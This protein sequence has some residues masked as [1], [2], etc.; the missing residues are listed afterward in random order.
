MAG[1]CGT[2]NK[3]HRVSEADDDSIV[4]FSYGMS[5][6]YG[7]AESEKKGIDLNAVECLRANKIESDQD[8]LPLECPFN[9]SLADLTGVSSSL[10][11]KGKEA[12]NSPFLNLSHS[13]ASFEIGMSSLLINGGNKAKPLFGGDRF[14]PC[15]PEDTHLDGAEQFQHE[16][17]LLRQTHTK[18]KRKRKRRNRN[19]VQDSSDSDNSS[20]DSLSSSSSHDSNSSS[21]GSEGS[22][23]QAS[24]QRQ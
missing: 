5:T 22:S 6:K 2:D 1:L 21:A 9:S 16:E 20:E 18:P 17:Y 3:G 8:S 10:K 7:A 23:H 15:R 4:S 11:T 24:R 12:S 19:N 14:I 13:K